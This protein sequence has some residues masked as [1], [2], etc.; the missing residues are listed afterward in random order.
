MYAEMLA[1][2]W[3]DDKDALC[4]VLATRDKTANSKQLYTLSRLKV[5]PHDRKK[6][7]KTYLWV[8]NIVAAKLY[9]CVVKICAGTF[10]N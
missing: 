7:E 1:G 5:N 4:R 2:C 8:I 9:R 10:L 3:W 6:K